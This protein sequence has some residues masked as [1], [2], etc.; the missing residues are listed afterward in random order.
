MAYQVY[1]GNDPAS[2]SF[3]I[4]TKVVGLKDVNFVVVN[5]SVRSTQDFKNISPKGELPATKGK[6]GSVTGLLEVTKTLIP[7]HIILGANESQQKEVVKWMKLL[8][9]DL[10]PQCKS[11][12]NRWVGKLHKFN[13]DLL[14]NVFFLGHQLS[15]VDLALFPLIHGAVK[16][17]KENDRLLFANLVRWFDFIQNLVGVNE[18]LSFVPVN[19]NLS[20]EQ[21]TAEQ[22]LKATD[23]KQEESHEVKNP[24]S[25][26]EKKNK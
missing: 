8:T 16:E 23:L 21:S 25:T 18:F 26:K 9:T 4:V 17:W 6:N 24:V 22:N 1:V 14:P 12:D 11:N 3:H 2:V 7:D 5:D 15:L 10:I 20:P 13:K 19:K